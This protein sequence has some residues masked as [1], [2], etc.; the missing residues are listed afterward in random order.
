MILIMISTVL[1]QLIQSLLLF[2]TAKRAIPLG[3]STIFFTMSVMLL[4][5]RGQ[6]FRTKFA[7]LFLQ[8]ESQ[9][10]HAFVLVALLLR[11]PKAIGTNSSILS[12]APTPVSV[13]N[14]TKVLLICT[15]VLLTILVQL[16]ACALKRK[17]K[18]NTCV[19]L[20]LF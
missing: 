3:V 11:F 6:I 20:K 12:S 8:K 7:S 18:R 1:R 19:S 17:M 13:K 9:R 10:L 16:F 4:L 15:I 14:L 5:V 2:K